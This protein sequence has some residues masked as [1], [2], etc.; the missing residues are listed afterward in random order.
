MRLSGPWLLTV[1]VAQGLVPQMRL[2]MH[3]LPRNETAELQHETVPTTSI[4]S[5]HACVDRSHP[6]LLKPNAAMTLTLFSCYKLRSWQKR[7]KHVDQT[8]GNVPSQA[9]V[10]V[11]VRVRVKQRAITGKGLTLP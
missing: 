1:M 10:R 6:Q 7:N 11:R 4:L 3:L 9:R 8:G 2:V 5:G